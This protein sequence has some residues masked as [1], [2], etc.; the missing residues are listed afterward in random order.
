MRT[1][2]YPSTLQQGLIAFAGLT[3]IVIVFIAGVLYAGI[4]GHDGEFSDILTIRQSDAP[5]GESD[6]LLIEYSDYE[7]PY[8]ARFHP[9]VQS[10]VESGEVEWVYR[11]LPLKKIHA[12]AMEGALIAECART[13]QSD[14]AFWEYTDAVFSSLKKSV[15]VYRDI[16]KSV[17]L[18]EGQMDNCLTGG[19]EAMAVVQLHISDARVLGVIGTPGSFLVNKRTGVFRVVP[20]AMPLDPLRELVERVRL[21]D[22]DDRESM[23][24]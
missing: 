15:A 13:Y 16:G 17:G 6:V 18:T 7:C 8:C 12:S 22:I 19:S 23:L 1:K 9:V 3:V 5:R 14:D 10:L 21:S 4:P 2:K 20:G 11:H 24:Y